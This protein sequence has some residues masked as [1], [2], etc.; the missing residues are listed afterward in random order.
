MS[1]EGAQTWGSLL[2][3]LAEGC[4]AREALV[5]DGKRVTFREIYDRSSRVAAA[6]VRAGVGRGD[7]VAILD[8]NTADWVVVFCAAALIGAAT[9]PVNTWYQ[10]SEIADQLQRSRAS[11][12]FTA[13]RLLKHDYAADLARILPELAHGQPLANECVPSLRSV[14]TI[15]DDCPIPGTDTLAEFVAHAQAGDYAVARS[16]QDAVSP[17]DVLHVLYTSGSTSR[18]KGVQVTHQGV[19]ENSLHVGSRMQ[20]T[21]D[22]RLWHSGPLFYGLATVFT[23]PATWL[24]GA[25]YLVQRSFDVEGALRLIER[26]RATAFAGY[27]NVTRALVEHE[28]FRD[29]DVSSMTKGATGFTRE[30]K[31]LAIEALGVRDVISIYGLTESH[32]P[33]FTTSAGDDRETVLETQGFVIPG[34]EYRFVA[35]HTDRPVPDGQDGELLIRGRTMLGYLDDS[36]ATTAVLDRDG[37]FRTGDLARLDA[38]GRLRWQARI[39]EVV[40]VGGV[41]VSPAEVED[42]IDAHP[43]VRE[44]HVVGIPDEKRGQVLV[45]FVEQRRSTLTED[46]VK[47][48]VA[49]RAARFKVPTHVLFRASAQ[50]PRVASGKMSKYLLIEEARRELGT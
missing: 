18:P 28:A 12:L 6:L 10:E 23:L 21:A 41:N 5:A 31:R 39:K 17:S 16:L 9:A 50:L 46:E 36:D 38:S 49:E 15:S 30:D 42:L 47:A 20:L 25:T 44:V 8:G 24:H 43:D 48:F 27:G 45:A 3:T 1:V 22:D 11:I 14:V 13:P 2:R 34:W 32:G 7:V 29:V 37:W 40:K 33:C 4:G 19:L 26:E 35:P